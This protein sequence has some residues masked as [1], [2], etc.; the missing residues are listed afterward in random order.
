MKTQIN[1]FKSANLHQLEVRNR[2]DDWKHTL[3]IF[4]L[5]LDSSA[6]LFGLC[7]VDSASIKKKN[8]I[9]NGY[10]Y[11]V[12]FDTFVSLWFDDVNSK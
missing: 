6:F 8:I 11:L 1:P 2:S 9:L 7:T 12:F 5:Y 3:T 10:F 4:Q